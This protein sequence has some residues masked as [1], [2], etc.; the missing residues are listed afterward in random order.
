MEEFV[1]MRTNKLPLLKTLRTLEGKI[2]PI[3]LLPPLSN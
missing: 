1:V 3:N 2:E